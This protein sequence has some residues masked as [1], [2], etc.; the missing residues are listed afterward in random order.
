MDDTIRTPEELRQH[1][2]V[3]ESCFPLLPRKLQRRASARLFE[4]VT[5]LVRK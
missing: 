1:F 5:M 3:V 4:G 2:E